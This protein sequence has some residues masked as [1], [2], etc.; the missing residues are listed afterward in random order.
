MLLLTT[1]VEARRILIAKL[2]ALEE[3]DSDAIA[4][5][6]YAANRR[7]QT[8]WR[9]GRPFLPPTWYIL[10]GPRPSESFDMADLATGGRD[11]IS[12]ETTDDESD[13]PQ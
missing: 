11:L 10:L 9:E 3:K 1:N 8:E 12:V 7:F 6:L 4:G 5:E 13:P 2:A